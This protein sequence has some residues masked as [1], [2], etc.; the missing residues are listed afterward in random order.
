MRKLRSYPLV[1]LDDGSAGGNNA[2]SLTFLVQDQLQTHWCWAAVAS[3][4]SLHYD[5]SSTWTQC[6]LASAE[7]APADC[8]KDGAA[9]TCDQAWALN[10][11]L[12][13]TGNLQFA[14][15]PSLAMSD[16]CDQLRANRPIGI[17][18]LWKNGGAHFLAIRGAYVDRQG[19]DRLLLTDP[20][21]GPS[22]C[23]VAVL[24]GYYQTDRG[25]WH[26]T[27]LTRPGR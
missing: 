3:S 9:K 12:M 13:R 18:V 27:Y 14:L 22:D 5:P 24:S 7:F 20:V 19:V 8:C 26:D 10:K 16:I 6:A 4:V 1:A 23:P 17:C 11:A 25:T 2:V 15:G 21:Y